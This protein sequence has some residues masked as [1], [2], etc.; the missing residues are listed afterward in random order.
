M[1]WRLAARN[2]KV[3]I[4]EARLG[5]QVGRRRVVSYRIRNVRITP[6]ETG[7]SGSLGVLDAA[8][9]ARTMRVARIGNRDR[10]ALV[11]ERNPALRQGYRVAPSNVATPATRIFLSNRSC[12]ALDDDAHSTRPFACGEPARISLTPRPPRPRA[13]TDLAYIVS[14]AESFVV[15]DGKRECLGQ[16]STALSGRSL[17]CSS[18]RRKQSLP[19]H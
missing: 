2:V 17:P 6:D 19:S 15:G 3:K 14:D 13:M 9:C 11:P 18:I 10:E 8:S 12:A 16:A 7:W 1:I 5:P 4:A